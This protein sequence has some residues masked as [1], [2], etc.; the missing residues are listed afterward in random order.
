MHDVQS[1]ENRGEVQRHSMVKRAVATAAFLAALVPAVAMA[2]QP[3]P[4]RTSAACAGPTYTVISND[5]WTLIASRARVTLPALLTANSATIATALFPGMSLCLPAGATVPTAPPNSAPTT[6]AP[7][8]TTTTPAGSAP[9]TTVPAPGSATTTAP[10]TT[11]PATTATTASIAQFPVQGPCFFVDTWGAPRSGGRKHEGVDIIAHQGLWVYAA[12]AGTLTKQYIDA[13]GRLSGNGWRLTAADGT[14][15]FYGHLSTFAAGLSVGSKV[16]TGQIIGQVGST[17]SS[18]TPHLH[19]EVHPGGGAA[20]NPTPVVKAVDGC[21]ITTVPT[22]PSGALPSPSATTVPATTPASTPGTTPAPPA[23]EGTSDGGQWKFVGP[24]V[25]LDTGWTGVKLAA[26]A[27]TTVPVSG[28]AGVDT[29]T[30]AVLVRVAT[31]NGGGTGWL[32]VHPCDAPLGS[33][34][35]NFSK[36]I[37]ANGVAAVRVVGGAICV[38]ASQSTDL[39]IDVIAVSTTDGVAPLPIVTT[40][41]V[42]TRSTQRLQAGGSLTLSPASLGA[43]AGTV[44]ISASI[45]VIDPTNRTDISFGPCGGVATTMTVAKQTIA[46]YAVVSKISSAGLCLTASESTHVLVDVNA[47]WIDAAAMEAVDPTRLF[48]ARTGA[49]TIGTTPQVIQ[50]AGVGSVPQ[51]ATTAIINITIVGGRQSGVVFAFPCGQPRPAASVAAASPTTISAV[52]VAVHLTNGAVCLST[53][54]PVPVVVD[55]IAV[56]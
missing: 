43:V 5:S 11:A 2:A 26:G 50:V 19:F 7:S 32:L 12:T 44:A 30:E 20:V 16:A 18:S 36:A 8:P 54:Q 41:A 4:T 34:T 3:H 45:T 9:A 21:K 38:T 47:V 51:D 6:T 46:A 55:V 28:L 53:F 23:S 1:H 37:R 25:A 39:R 10:A 13:P 56:G 52:S 48:D 27:K 40:R 14:Y 15:F 42:D 29:A 49:G 22:Q 35:L 31:R 17:G 24:T 33:S